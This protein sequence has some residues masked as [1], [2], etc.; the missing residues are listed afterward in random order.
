[1][2]PFFCNNFDEIYKVAELAARFLVRVNT[3]NG[4]YKDEIMR[5][6]RIGLGLTG[7]HEFAWKFF[8]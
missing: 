6:Q 8:N 3:M 2:V 7:I 1:M 5:T 4:I